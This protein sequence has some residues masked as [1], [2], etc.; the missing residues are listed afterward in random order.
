MHLYAPGP[1]RG[2][3]LADLKSFTRE[4]ADPYNTVYGR[5]SAREDA[6][7]YNTVYGRESADAGGPGRADADVPDQSEEEA[8][9]SKV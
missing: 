5:E 8:Y 2:R 7:P 6:D 3:R 1:P 9:S 4:D